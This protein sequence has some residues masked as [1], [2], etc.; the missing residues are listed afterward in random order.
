MVSGLCV[1]RRGD[2]KKGW[3]RGRVE[4]GRVGE[5]ERERNRYTYVYRI[6]GKGQLEIG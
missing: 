5:R 2:S 1:A 3:E 6:A 4:G